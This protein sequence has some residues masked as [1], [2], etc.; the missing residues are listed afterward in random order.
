[1]TEYEVRSMD[2]VD[3]E[4][5]YERKTFPAAVATARH[6][7]DELG[8]KAHVWQRENDGEWVHVWPKRRWWLPWIR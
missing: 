6:I 8:T 4:I 2:L 5:V 7:R 3:D 1:M